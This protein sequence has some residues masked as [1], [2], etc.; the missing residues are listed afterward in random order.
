MDISCETVDH[1]TDQLCPL[2]SGI[3]LGDDV[4]GGGEVG[5]FG[6]SAKLHGTFN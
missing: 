4:V 1:F 2:K 5:I 6:K 3:S